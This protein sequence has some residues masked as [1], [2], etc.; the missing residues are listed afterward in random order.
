MALETYRA[1]RNFKITAEP[2]GSPKTASPTPHLSFVVQK[3]QATQL[4]YDFRLEWK[5]VLLSWAVPK[6][7]SLDPSV[8][9]LAM[10]VEDHPLE[11]GGFEG[12][13]PEGEYG[14]GTVMV[15]DRGTWEPDDPEVDASLK[16][17][18]LK[19]TLHGSKLKGS[20]VLVRTRGFGKSTKPSWLLIKHKDRYA[21]SQDLV[22]EQPKSALSKRLMADIATT[23]GAGPDTVA[24]AAKADPVKQKRK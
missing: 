18:D 9:R 24:K 10:A 6:G 23:A 2:K 12:T 16:T 4:H 1:K 7:P 11:Y 19:F 3:H 21:S 14:G 22:T 13:I 17:G 8:K 20:W 15:W 5:G